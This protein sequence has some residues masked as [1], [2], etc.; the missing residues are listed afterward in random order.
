LCCC[1]QAESLTALKEFV[2]SAHQPDDGAKITGPVN[3]D[4][5]AID[6][7][8]VSDGD[9]SDI[10]EDADLTLCGSVLTPYCYLQV[11][12]QVIQAILTRAYMD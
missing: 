4:Q 1:F 7:Y 10:A 5:D 9:L 2:G 6:F 11:L 3:H 8:N 12:G